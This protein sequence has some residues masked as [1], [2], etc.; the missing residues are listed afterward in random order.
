MKKNAVYVTTFNDKKVEESMHEILEYCR[1]NKMDLKYVIQTNIE[2]IT[3]EPEDIVNDLKEHGCDIVV[4]N[5]FDLLFPDVQDYEVTLLEELKKNEIECI[6]TKN[7]YSMLNMAHY[8][9]EKQSEELTKQPNDVKGLIVY[10]GIEGYKTDEE[11][12][13]MIDYMEERMDEGAP[14]GVLCYENES[15]GIFEAMRN[16]LEN[17]PVEEVILK[18]EFATE[19]GIELIKQ[20]KKLEIEVIT[21]EDLRYEMGQNICQMS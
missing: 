11:Y 7:G 14:F 1:Q 12:L 19:E 2:K 17:N 5:D 21:Y 6:Y 15:N 3:F 16:I 4:S 18:E 20:M 13:D 9:N 10:R 8:I